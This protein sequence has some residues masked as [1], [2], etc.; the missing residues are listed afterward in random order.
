MPG[1]VRVWGH[2]RWRLMP[3]PA[4]RAYRMTAWGQSPALVEAPVP[5]AGPGQ[6]VVR[7]AAC[8]LCHS[9]LAM[10]AMPAVV[11]EA[12]GWDIAFT[13]GHET[14]GWVHEVGDDVAGLTIGDAVAVAS[15]ASCGACRWCLEGR[16]NACSEGLVGRGYGRDGG[17]AELVLVVVGDDIAVVRVDDTVTVVARTAE[18]V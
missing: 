14:A 8:G 15:P 2:L 12:L 9:D 17:L 18:L 6:V 7:V 5:V 16:E 1:S 3:S 11:G 13:L 10:M 4:M